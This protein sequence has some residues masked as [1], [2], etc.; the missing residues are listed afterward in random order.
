AYTPPAGFIPV[1]LSTKLDSGVSKAWI[2]PSILARSVDARIT[3]SHTSGVADFRESALSAIA[4]GMP[5]L[6]AKN[7]GQ[8]IEE[9][10]LVHLRP[11]GASVALFVGALTTSDGV[12]MR[13]MQMLFPDDT[14]SSIVTA[15]F[16]TSLN[17]RMMPV[18][19]KSMDDATGVKKVGK[20]APTWIVLSWALGG[21]LLAV[22][23]QTIIGRR[24]RA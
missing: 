13:T 6:Y 9:R 10:H 3:L 12:K 20:P 18:I 5:A 22:A 14:G 19:E 23:A 11:D 24:K 17:L 16:E 21:L 4:A 7:R 15:S 2:E 1:D 8:W